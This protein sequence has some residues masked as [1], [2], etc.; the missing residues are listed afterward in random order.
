MRVQRF[1]SF[2]ESYAKLLESA[3]DISLFLYNKDRKSF[4]AEV[5][6]LKGKLNGGEKEISIFNPD[7]NK[8]VKFT[9]TKVDK[10]G[11]EE[12]TYGWNYENK[13]LGLKLL[14]IND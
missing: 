1:D 4:S 10:D 9:F 7:T 6:E 8:T 11:S 2:N 12:D 3:L 13:E 5:S 14:I